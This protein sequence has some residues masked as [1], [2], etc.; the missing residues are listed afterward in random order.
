MN[1]THTYTYTEEQKPG[2]ICANCTT[3]SSRVN[4]DKRYPLEHILDSIARKEEEGLNSCDQ[5]RRNES[6]HVHHWKQFLEKM[7]ACATIEGEFGAFPLPFPARRRVYREAFELH[8]RSVI[9][10]KEAFWF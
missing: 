3:R 9:V 1:G 2:P 4:K 7:L 5:L 8:V 10:L 6:A